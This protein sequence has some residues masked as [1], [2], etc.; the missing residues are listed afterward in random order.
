[1]LGCC[2]QQH[3]VDGCGHWKPVLY[4]ILGALNR[5]QVG[6]PPFATGRWGTTSSWT[7]LY[8][9]TCGKASQTRDVS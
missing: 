9:E 7:S 6:E 2:H 1:M 5:L 8:G 3:V 4:G